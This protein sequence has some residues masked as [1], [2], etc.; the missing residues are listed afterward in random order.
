M[1]E[2]E[3]WKSVALAFL[4]ERVKQQTERVC[5]LTW[6]Q[7]AVACPARSAKSIRGHSLRKKR[8]RRRGLLLDGEIERKNN[9]C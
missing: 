9:N 2:T 5:C 6:E 3:E 8:R 4:S 1:L 7:V